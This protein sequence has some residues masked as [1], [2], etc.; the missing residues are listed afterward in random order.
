MYIEITSKEAC[1]VIFIGIQNFTCATHL[2]GFD[3]VNHILF[4]HDTCSVNAKEIYKYFEKVDKEFK[5]YWCCSLTIQV[6]CKTFVVGSN[7]K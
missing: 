5:I 7:L 3:W 2:K 1:L 4:L 6:A